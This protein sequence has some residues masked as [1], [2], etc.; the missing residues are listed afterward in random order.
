MLTKTMRTP[1]NSRMNTKVLM[2][3][4]VT[5][6]EPNVELARVIWESCTM[7]V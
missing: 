1:M 7:G 4:G 5:M 6:K 3:F 2:H